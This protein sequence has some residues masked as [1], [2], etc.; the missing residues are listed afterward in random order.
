M[1]LSAM[2]TANRGL[3]S[4]QYVHRVADFVFDRRRVISVDVE[5]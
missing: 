4:S 2:R 5:D 3:A 1:V